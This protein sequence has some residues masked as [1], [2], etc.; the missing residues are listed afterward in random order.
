M[1]KFAMN[2]FK[3]LR[4]LPVML[5]TMSCNAA[6]KSPVDKSVIDK[7][8]SHYFATSIK[9]PKDG[10]PYF[11]AGDFNGDGMED[12]VVLFIPKA[13]PKIT[14]Q[15]T[16]DMPWLYPDAPVSSTYTTSLVIF[17]G[18]QKDWLSDKTK[19]FVMLDTSGVLETPSFELMV[20]RKSD[21]NYKDYSAMLPVKASGDL[22]V[23]PTEAGIDTFIYWDNG[24]YKLLNQEDMP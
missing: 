2:I 3:V 22:I 14:A 6:E 12:V 23:L 7:L 19:F 16:I 4:V 20:T 8:I 1:E 13:R 17:H 15:L 10:K 18:G 24:S 11:K 9:A 5:L 21:K